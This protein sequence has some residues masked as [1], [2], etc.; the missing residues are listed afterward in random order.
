MTLWIGYVLHEH[1][2]ESLALQHSCKKSG[3]VASSKRGDRQIPG[4]PGL[5]CPA[6][7]ES[8][9]IIERACPPKIR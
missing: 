6:N 1:K 9:R 4:A 5:T 7:T 8:S 2:V 3:L